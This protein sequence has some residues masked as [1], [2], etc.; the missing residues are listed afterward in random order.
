MQDDNT[1]MKLQNPLVTS[2]IWWFERAWRLSTVKMKYWMKR[3]NFTHN[4]INKRWKYVHLT[5]RHLLAFYKGF[6]LISLDSYRL[7]YYVPDL[8]RFIQS[9]SKVDSRDVH[10]KGQICFKLTF[11][12]ARDFDY[13]LKIFNCTVTLP[14]LQ[15]RNIGNDSEA[16]NF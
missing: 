14:I 13:L 16:C 10:L 15:N 7:L 3:E 1:K 8:P 11:S 6:F 9:I 12:P 2:P 4:K 5:F